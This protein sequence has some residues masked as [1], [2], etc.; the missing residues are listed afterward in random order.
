[1]A[2][3]QGQATFARADTEHRLF[4]RLPSF[5]QLRAPDWLVLTAVKSLTVVDFPAGIIR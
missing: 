4:G 2:G 3:H 1:M 5:T